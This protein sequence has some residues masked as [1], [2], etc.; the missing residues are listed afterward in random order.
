MKG[1]VQNMKK[2]NNVVKESVLKMTTQFDETATFETLTGLFV[3][4]KICEV[5]H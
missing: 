4:E 3:Q 5:E 2:T 1:T